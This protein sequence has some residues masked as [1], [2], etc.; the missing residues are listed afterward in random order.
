MSNIFDE[1]IADA[2]RLKEIAEQNAKNRIIEAVTPKIKRL[3]EAEISGD[4]DLDA[5]LD[6]EEESDEYEEFDAGGTDMEVDA[7]GDLDLSYNEPV[8]PTM[9]DDFGMIEDDT[10][11]YDIDD[12][13]D[14]EIEEESPKKNVVINV[15][16]ESARKSALNNLRKNKAKKLLEA[17][18]NCR[19]TTQKQKLLSELATLRNQCISSNSKA[20]KNLARKLSTL[21][22]ETKMSR[23]TRKNWF[24][25]EGEGEGEEEDLDLGG[26]EG[27]EDED[28]DLEDEGDADIDVDA[29]KAAIEDLADAVG[30]EV[31]EEDEDMEDEDMEDEDL[32]ENNM[33]ESDDQ[34]IEINESALRRDLMR[35]KHNARNRRSRRISESR[36]HRHAASRRRRLFEAEAVDAASSFGGGTAED[37]MFIDVDENTLINALAEE[38][39]D[40]HKLDMNID[41]SGSA[42]KMAGHFGGGKA[43]AVRE[44]RR[45]RAIANKS[46]MIESRAKQAVLAERKKAA[47]AQRELK[48]SN[49]F[50]A[51][52]LYVNKLMQQHVLNKK[53]QR[54]IVEALDNAKT[55]REAKLLFEGLSDSLSKAKR[56]SSKSL[57]ESRVISGSSSTATRSSAPASTQMSSELDRWQKLAGIKK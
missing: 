42:P 45:R 16:V 44:A 37:E 56:Q 17:I 22:K 31:A 50:N 18:K 12:D 8:E 51:K 34:V 54:A 33:Y 14:L 21:L 26:D 11:D 5:D 19:N 15:T 28:M 6:D 29:I 1:A 49:L 30:L 9:P 7:S 47:A 41:G 4:P 35:M 23:R 55:L 39:G 36:R 25:F 48:E 43:Q 57:N 2:K 20:D 24:L 53:Q 52:L 40:A 27:M 3:I 32:E 13:L 10:E 38:L 46:R